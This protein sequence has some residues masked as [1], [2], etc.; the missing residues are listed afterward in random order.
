MRA[1][2]LCAFILLLCPKVTTALA[3]PIT[4]KPKTS[5]A[6]PKTS[7]LQQCNEWTAIVRD[8]AAANARGEPLADYIADL[9]KSGED[10]AS[11]DI[12]LIERIYES[13]LSPDDIAAL[14][15]KACYEAAQQRDNT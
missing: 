2:A 6:P 12:Q 10:P 4:P 8:I 5:P 15:Q 1:L 14:W 7:G 3:I 9:Q 11:P 13:H